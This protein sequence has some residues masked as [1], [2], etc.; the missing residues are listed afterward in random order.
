MYVLTKEEGGRHSG[1]HQNYKPQIY[2]RTADEAATLY[3]PEGTE[4]A[5][6]KMVMPGDNVE[7]MCNIN[8]P[9][10]IEA[11]QRFNVREGGRTV[12]TGLVTRILK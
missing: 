4:D 5:N 10:A 2:I 9:I 11:G 8:H 12:A 1:F 7:M 6:S 3:W